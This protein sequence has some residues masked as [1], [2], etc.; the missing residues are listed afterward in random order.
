MADT[1]TLSRIAR[2]WPRLLLLRPTLAGHSTCMLQRERHDFAVTLADHIKCFTRRCAWL[3]MQKLP[4]PQ[5]RPSKSIVPPQ[6]NVMAVNQQQTTC[7]MEVTLYAVTARQQAPVPPTP[8]FHRPTTEHVNE[9]F[10]RLILERLNLRPET[11]GKYSELQ[12]YCT[13]LRPFAKECEF[14]GTPHHPNYEPT[15]EAAKR[16][17]Y[18][19]LGTVIVAG[20]YEPETFFIHRNLLAERTDFFFAYESLA[21]GLPGIGI[22]NVPRENKDVVAAYVNFVYTGTLHTELSEN[23]LLP[24][25]FSRYE[26][27][28]QVCHDDI[29]AQHLFLAELCVFGIKIKDAEFSDAA[30]NRMAFLT[31]LSLLGQHV[32]PDEYA[33]KTIY[34]GSAAGSPYRA[35]VVDLYYRCAGRDTEWSEDTYHLQF[36]SELLTK[37]MTARS[38]L[39]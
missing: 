23:V 27:G 6:G 19:K 21:P 18:N 28:V 39:V 14:D 17:R 34:N 22:C 9:H 3:Q 5:E 16:M 38:W 15:L 8:S 35:S 20:A 2:V 10:Q 1:K 12:D 24:L 11:V 7:S 36:L 30:I 37:T 13:K 4:G 25:W 26:D 31:N 32:L 29:E 33:V